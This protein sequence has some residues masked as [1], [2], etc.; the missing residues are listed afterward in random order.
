[1]TASSL[2]RRV[3][4]NKPDAAFDWT[5]RFDAAVRPSN[6]GIGSEPFSSP[7]WTADIP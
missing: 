1:M 7:S 4:W 6:I 3:Q 5:E 2:V